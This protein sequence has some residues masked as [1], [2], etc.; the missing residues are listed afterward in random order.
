MWCEMKR[1]GANGLETPLACGTYGAAYSQVAQ[2]K[3]KMSRIFREE[4]GDD[5]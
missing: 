3:A 5:E 2:R 4:P 1:R